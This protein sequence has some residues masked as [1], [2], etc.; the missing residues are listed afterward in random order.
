M[1]A[2]SVTRHSALT[3]SALLLALV[4]GGGGSPSP[5]PEI[6]LQCAFALF[7]IAVLLTDRRRLPYPR[8]A[9]ILAGLMLIVPVLQLVPLPAAIWHSLPGRETASRAMA[10]IDEQNAWHGWALDPSLTL[11][12]LL[13]LLPVA[14]LLL[15]ASRLAEA[16]RPLVLAAIAVGGVLTMLVGAAQLSQGL[17]GPLRFYHPVSLYLDGFQA[18]H[19]STADVL[20]VAMVASIALLRHAAD[21]RLVSAGAPTVLATAFGIIA[22]FALGVALTGSRMGIV[23]LAPALIGCLALL[24]PW[25]KVS[26]KVAGAAGLAVSMV[27]AVILLAA[28]NNDA[29]AR[30]VARFDFTGEARPGLWQDAYFAAQTYFPFGAGMGNFIPAMLPGERLEIVTQ[31]IPNRA[32]NELLELAVE[33]GLFALAAWAAIAA[34]SV[35]LA[36][37]SSRGANNSPAT[38]AARTML[39]ILVA[40]SMVDYPFRSMALACVGAA[41]LALLILPSGSPSSRT[42]HSKDRNE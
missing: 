16:Q 32:H 20:L 18:N 25:I 9:L 4:L 19:N 42:E 10:L 41:C 23:L 29:L 3:A 22:L 37:R 34:I 11:A 1:A 26:T 21:R 27:L 35:H 6:A 31:T 14:W 13:S 39:L 15:Q 24:K 38:T 5:L 28:R 7:A 33:G 36:W 40:H 2:L 8:I 12:S 17:N 30:V